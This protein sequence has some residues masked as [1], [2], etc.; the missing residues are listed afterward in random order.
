MKRKVG[1]PQLE[2]REKRK[3]TSVR[4]DAREL[5]MWSEITKKLG[6]SIKVE[7]SATQALSWCIKLMGERLLGRNWQ[8]GDEELR[9]LRLWQHE[10]REK[11]IAS[12][13]YPR[14]IENIYLNPEEQVMVEASAK[15]LG[16]ML[17]EQA[18]SQSYAITYALLLA[19]KVLN[20]SPRK[21]ENEWVKKELSDSI[22][23]LILGGLNE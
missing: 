6:Q 18:H 7:M 8:L 13:E 4:M 16:E 22:E 17:G 3:K 1:R 12:H 15:V 10:I 5:G 20:I 2:E 9:D 23:E 21:A 14:K 11:R 19:A